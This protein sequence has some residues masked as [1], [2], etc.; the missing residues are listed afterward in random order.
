MIVTPT[1]RNDA[2]DKAELVTQHLY[3]DPATGSFLY[4]QYQGLNL[5]DESYTLFALL[6]GDMILGLLR[7]SQFASELEEVFPDLSEDDALKVAQKVKA[8]IQ[9][10][11]EVTPSIKDSGSTATESGLAAAETKPEIE[12]VDDTNRS[13]QKQPAADIPAIRT[14]NADRAAAQGGGESENPHVG[15]QANQ[16]SETEEAEE[17]TV[18]SYSQEDLLRRDQE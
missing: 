12:S 2:I 5:S 10:H 6:A 17:V 16:T 14:M 3:A 8:F 11:S 9:Q 7:A 1:Q 18:P 13:A 4:K 15:Y